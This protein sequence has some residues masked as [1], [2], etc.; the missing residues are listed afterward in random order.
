MH[1][2]PTTLI[3][4]ALM[5]TIAPAPAAAD[6]C[7][8]STYVFFSPPGVSQ[9]PAVR[10]ALCNAEESTVGGSNVPVDSA[11]ITPGSERMFIRHTTGAAGSFSAVLNGIGFSNVAVPL[12]AKG[13]FY[14]S[15]SI[16]IPPTQTLVLGTLTVDILKDG[17]KIDSVVYRTAV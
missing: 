17:V 1:W 5:A 12:V 10:P 6:S 2:L 13:S 15:A 11:I 9:S 16:N 3:A 4:L 14:D 7:P 8:A